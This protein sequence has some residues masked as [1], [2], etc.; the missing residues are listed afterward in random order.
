MIEEEQTIADH[1]RPISPQH[2]AALITAVISGVFGTIQSMRAPDA[3]QT[4]QGIQRAASAVDQTYETLA[5]NQNILAKAV[6]RLSRRNI[7]LRGRVIELER[8]LKRIEEGVDDP[9][10][11]I[12]FE[13]SASSKIIKIS[14]LP[15]LPDDDE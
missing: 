5:A 10:P 7:R 15:V 9:L 12:Q 4:R 6:E 11:L 8:A 3:E 1:P 2:R 13:D 14:P